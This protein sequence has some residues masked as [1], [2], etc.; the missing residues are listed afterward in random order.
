VRRHLGCVIRTAND[1]IP[2][3]SPGIDEKSAKARSLLTGKTLRVL[4]G[5]SGHRIVGG[6]RYAQALDKVDT[7]LAGIAQVTSLLDMSVRTRLSMRP[8][9]TAISPPSL[10]IGIMWHCGLPSK[11][12][13]G[14]ASCNSICCFPFSRSRMTD[15][16]MVMSRNGL[17]RAKTAGREVSSGGGC[18]AVPIAEDRDVPAAAAARRLAYARWPHFERW[19]RVREATFSQPGLCLYRCD[20]WSG[21]HDVDDAGKIVGEHVQRH[22]GGDAW[23]CLH[24]EMGCSHPR[25]DCPERMLD[26]LAPLAHF[27]WMLVEPALHGFENKP[28]VAQQ[29]FFWK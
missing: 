4:C 1:K 22:F 21:P 2:T 25:L 16:S 13:P 24:K 17:G 7:R 11:R 10:A 14:Q 15:G 23:Q 20:Q 26:R 19:N 12:R 8:K 28:S 27:F 18:R 9:L 6:T 5:I 29:C 3:S